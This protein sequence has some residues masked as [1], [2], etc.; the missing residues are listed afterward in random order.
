MINVLD[1][2]HARARALLASGAPVFLPVNPVEYHGPHL[3]LHNDLLVSQGV[4]RELHADL[5]RRG[6]DWPLLVTSDLEIGVDPTPGPGSCPI[7]YREASARVVSAC[8]SLAELGAQRVVLVTFHGSPLH[9]LALDAGV[10]WLKRRGIPALSPLNILLRGMLDINV[11][12]YADAYGAIPNDEDRAAAMREGATDVHAGFFE[13]SVTMHYAPTS[14]DPIY[15]SLPPCPEITHDAALS[16]ASR[17]ADK[18]GA[19]QLAKELRLAA[20]GIGWHALRPFPGYT[21]RPSLAS[22]EAGAVI[23]GH[24]IEQFGRATEQVLVS[25]A[26]PPA[27]IMPWL[28]SLTLGGTLPS[29]GAIPVEAIA[30][31]ERASSPS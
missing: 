20:F 29:E 27:P 7:G 3:S 6:H 11:D 4:A 19:K 10:R 5:A 2:S 21:C 24:M 28:A 14:V 22:P 15:R 23:A 9:S 12:D 26:L 13:T 8:R 1:V 18:L 16:A 25:G 17:A 30:R 31:F